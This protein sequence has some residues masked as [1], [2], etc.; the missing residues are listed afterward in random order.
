MKIKFLFTPA[1]DELLQ[2]Y[3]DGWTAL[4]YGKVWRYW[5]WSG[6]CE[7]A[8]KRIAFEIGCSD[9]TVRNKLAILE[10]DGYIKKTAN[11]PGK[12]VRWVPTG[13]LDFGVVVG[14]Y[15][16]ESDSDPP[17]SDSDLTPES[18]SDK[19]RFK[20]ILN[21]F[22]DDK[23]GDPDFENEI[24]TYLDSVDALTAYI[25]NINPDIKPIESENVIDL[26]SDHGEDHFKQ[27]LKIAVFQNVKKISYIERVLENAA[28]YDYDFERGN[29][30]KT[31][32]KNGNGN[33][34]QDQKTSNKS[35][36]YEGVESVGFIQGKLKIK[37]E[38]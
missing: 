13:K 27:A 4:V 35:S 7:A 16:P 32:G 2:K 25:D 21:S 10:K 1:A 23:T 24:Q 15:T 37:S 20:K 14:T 30:K 38:K 19:E 3:N 26:I 9:R 6:S 31:G 5:D 36:A 11:E 29:P 33:S 12:P 17:E 22:N 28:K 34:R 18:D 8:Q